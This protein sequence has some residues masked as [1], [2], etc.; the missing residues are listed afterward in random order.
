M[1]GG[2]TSGA[3]NRS[4]VAAAAAAAAAELEL[5][6][7]VAA[8]LPSLP[9]ES[10]AAR[11]AACEPQ[12]PLTLHANVALLPQVVSDGPHGSKTVSV[13]VPVTDWTVG[14]RKV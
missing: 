4:A 7:V 8:P 12:F 1:T 13:R 3:E 5:V 9:P 11:A 14:A 2:T 6:K 10:S